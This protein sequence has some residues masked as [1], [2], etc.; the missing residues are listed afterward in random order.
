MRR[1]GGTVAKMEHLYLVH[2]LEVREKKTLY[3]H[4]ETNIGL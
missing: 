1:C 2:G 3:A 4:P